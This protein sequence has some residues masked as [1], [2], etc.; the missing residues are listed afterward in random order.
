M[1]GLG[2]DTE[3]KGSIKQ[4]LQTLAFILAKT[5]GILVERHVLFTLKQGKYKGRR[6]FASEDPQHSLWPRSILKPPVGHAFLQKIWAPS[7]P[8]GPQTATGGDPPHL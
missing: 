6:K 2:S 7:A 3:E 8:G 4:A 5:D 1:G